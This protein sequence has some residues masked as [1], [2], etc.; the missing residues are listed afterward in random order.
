MRAPGR[1]LLPGGRN[2]M[3]AMDDLYFID[4][5]GTTEGPFSLEKLRGLFAV[6]SINKDT[7]WTMPGAAQWIRLSELPGL[8]LTYSSSSA[9]AYQCPRCASADVQAFSVLHLAGI[10]S[11]SAFGVDVAGD[12]GAIGGRTQ[13]LLSIVASPPKKKNMNEGFIIGFVG[14]LLGLFFWFGASQCDAGNIGGAVFLIASVVSIFL[15]VIRSGSNS[16]WN[17]ERFPSLY[18]DWQSSWLCKRCGNTWISTR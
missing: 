18:K 13:S 4:R 5:G 16:R 7:L 12:F 6:Q 14:C 10:S 11:T 1:A 9:L 8:I 15:G 17:R 2:A 3:K